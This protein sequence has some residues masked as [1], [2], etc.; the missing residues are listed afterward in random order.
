MQINQKMDLHQ[1]LIRRNNNFLI[2]FNGINLE[3]LKKQYKY[4]DHQTD[5][6]KNDLRVNLLKD[7]KTIQYESHPR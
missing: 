1:D 4:I 7:I 3:T 2:N 6:I 5:K